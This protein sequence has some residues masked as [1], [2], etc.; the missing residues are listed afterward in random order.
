MYV[1]MYVCVFVPRNLRGFNAYDHEI[2][3]VGLISANLKYGS[4]RIL[5]YGLGGAGLPIWALMGFSR[6]SQPF[7]TVGP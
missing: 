3:H 1:C 2:W 6:L 4:I 5:I 7:E